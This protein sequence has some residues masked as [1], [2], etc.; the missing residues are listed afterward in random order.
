MKIHPS[1]YLILPVFLG[2]LTMLLS[3]CGHKPLTPAEVDLRDYFYGGNCQD[4][5]ISKYITYT[6]DGGDTAV[7]YTYVD[8]ENKGDEYLITVNELN[9]GFVKTSYSLARMG[10]CKGYESFQERYNLK[11][12]NTIDTLEVLEADDS[13]I[14]DCK[15]YGGEFGSSEYTII[16]PLESI[17]YQ[18]QRDIISR[19]A[20]Y[21]T[22]YYAN[23]LGKDL[24]TLQIVEETR[25]SRFFEDE[26]KGGEE[27][28]STMLLVKGYGLVSSSTRYTHM[29]TSFIKL[30]KIMT[31]DEFRQEEQ[32]FVKKNPQFKDLVY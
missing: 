29:T 16:T 7:F 20:Y 13:L 17:V 1:R 31:L 12:D 3:S 15:L 23:Y 6:L 10:K 9:S 14:Y 8:C 24:P 32:E 25:M 2:I 30:V 19:K 26:L 22:M 27:T 21:D 11:V 5:M 4:P 28:K 18:Y